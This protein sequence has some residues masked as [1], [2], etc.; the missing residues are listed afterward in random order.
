ME[1]TTAEEV[2]VA[3]VDVVTAAGEEDT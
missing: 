3:V 2:G 1:L